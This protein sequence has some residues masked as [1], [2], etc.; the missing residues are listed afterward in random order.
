MVAQASLSSLLADFTLR[1]LPKSGIYFPDFSRLPTLPHNHTLAARVTLRTLRLNCLTDAY[2][3]LWAECWDESFLDDSPILTR[4][5]DRPIGPEWTADVPLRR[6][7]DRRNAQAEIDVM[8]AMMLGVTAEDLCTLYRTQFAVLYSNDHAIKKSRNPYV[9]DTNGRQLPT[10]VRQAWEKRKRP[11]SNEDMPLSE[12][13]HTHPGSGVSYVY[14]LPFRIR[15]RES[16]FRR[17]HTALTQPGLG[18]GIPT[19]SE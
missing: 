5:D 4:Y 13:T 3:D 11:T 7:E 2:A 17:I 14:D 15:D 12:R 16:D 6:A 1:A 8:V 18:I 19:I 9:Y 10:P